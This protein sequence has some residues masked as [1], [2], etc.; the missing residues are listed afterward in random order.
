MA[1][2]Q[3]IQTITLWLSNQ[4]E[5]QV[6]FSEQL[7]RFKKYRHELARRSPNLSLFRQIALVGNIAAYLAF[8]LSQVGNATK[9]AWIPDRDKITE[10]YDSIALDLFEMNHFGLCDEAGIEGEKIQILLGVPDECQ[11]NQ[12]F[13][14]LIRIPDYL[15]GA[16]ASLD[17]QA[18]HATLPKHGDVLINVVANNENCFVFQVTSKD[19]ALVIGQFA[20]TEINS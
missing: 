20:A 9:I 12:W 11:V 8:L 14:R 17:L 4:P 5:G 6:K 10:A 1:V 3:A 19:E 18:E 15:A 13:D 7:Q 16:L 2:D